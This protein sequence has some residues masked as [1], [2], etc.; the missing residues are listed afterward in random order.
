[1]LLSAQTGSC[2]GDLNVQ[3]LGALN[4]GLAVAGR[5]V[6]GNLSHKNLK[7]DARTVAEYVRLCISNTSS[8]CKLET[9]KFL[10]PS[11]LMK[12]VYV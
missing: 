4:N 8:S 1:M 5:D 2:V 9:K 12:R 11:L 7:N 3:L 6:V 10:K